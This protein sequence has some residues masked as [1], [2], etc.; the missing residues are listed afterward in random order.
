MK[1]IAI[2]GAGPAGLVTLKYLLTSHHFLGNEPVEVKLFEAEDGVG[3]TFYARM[4]ENGEVSMLLIVYCSSSFS[5]GTVNSLPSSS[6]ASI[7]VSFVLIPSCLPLSCHCL[8]V[9]CHSCDPVHTF[10]FDGKASSAFEPS[11]Y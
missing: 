7:L 10:L 3:G 6:F 8:H 11:C 5:L 2:V 1:K 9:F 4:Y